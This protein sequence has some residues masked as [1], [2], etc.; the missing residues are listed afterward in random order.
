ML[1]PHLL[2]SS[3]VHVNTLLLQQ[4]LAEPK[5]RRG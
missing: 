4:N 3:L 1:A 2:E 5:R